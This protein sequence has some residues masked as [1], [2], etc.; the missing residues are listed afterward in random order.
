MERALGKLQEL[1]LRE[2]GECVHHHEECE[3][4]EDVYNDEE[5]TCGAEEEEEEA[6]GWGGLAMVCCP[7]TIRTLCKKCKIHQVRAFPLHACA[8]DP[9]QQTPQ[10]HPPRPHPPSDP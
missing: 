10:Q 4:E 8:P 6:G 3:G 7:K 1:S 5:C 2:G 9:R